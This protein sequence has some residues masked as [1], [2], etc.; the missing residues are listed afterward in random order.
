MNETRVGYIIYI[1]IY[2]VIQFFFL[3]KKKDKEASKRHGQRVHQMGQSR[4]WRQ[5][6]RSNM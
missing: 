2:I 3:N 1:Y 5:V 6:N 4:R